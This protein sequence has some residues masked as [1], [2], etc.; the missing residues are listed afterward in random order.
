WYSSDFASL[1]AKFSSYVQAQDDALQHRT[2]FW[3][4]VG[5]YTFGGHLVDPTAASLYS[6]SSPT[7]SAVS[8]VQSQEYVRASLQELGHVNDSAPF[9][10]DSLPLGQAAMLQHNI[11]WDEGILATGNT[12]I[13]V[14]L[15]DS[16]D[17]LWVGVVADLIVAAFA[18]I[19]RLAVYMPHIY[20]MVS[21][22]QRLKHRALAAV[23]SLSLTFIRRQR[24]RIMRSMKKRAEMHGSNEHDSA[25]AGQLQLLALLYAADEADVD[26]PTALESARPGLRAR[27]HSVQSVDTS[28]MSEFPALSMSPSAAAASSPATRS[29]KDS[30]SFTTYSMLVSMAPSIT[31]VLLYVLTVYLHQAVF[32]ASSQYTAD[33]L[34]ANHVASAQAQYSAAVM[35]FLHVGDARAA[36][37]SPLAQRTAEQGGL[38]ISAFVLSR[39]EA[40]ARVES[41]ERVLR[42]GMDRI[43]YAGGLVY[44]NISVQAPADLAVAGQ[45]QG[46]VLESPLQEF[47]LGTVC[48]LPDLLGGKSTLTGIGFDAAL[49]TPDLFPATGQAHEKNC[50]VAL[51]G[52]LHRT[53]LV[54]AVQ[55]FIL[56]GRQVVSSIPLSDDTS[57]WQTL[58]ATSADALHRVRAFHSLD[59]SHMRHAMN[60]LVRLYDG[61]FQV[62]ED[63]YLWSFLDMMVLIP[64]LL[65]SV[66]ALVW[67]YML[68]TGADS[69]ASL[70]LL[71]LIPPK[72]LSVTPSAA[73]DG[74]A[75]YASYPPAVH[76]TIT[77][78]QTVASHAA[79]SRTEDVSLSFEDDVQRG[80]CA[81]AAH[82][83]GSTGHLTALSSGAGAADGYDST[84]S[85]SDADLDS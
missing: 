19:L 35:D 28:D 2:R 4:P 17:L 45:V 61:Q 39:A 50:S 40:A 68:Q 79:S 8:P 47:L 31:L 57:T 16:V 15:Q 77:R 32:H 56:F 46:L 14:L 24:S 75:S 36:A 52:L 72:E 43:M 21:A 22:L 38:N 53:G 5:G 64:L 30:S 78:I 82:D 62:V 13:R 26:A 27:G 11:E 41:A 59:E 37:A 54:G 71:L 1:S 83:S 80:C 65:I 63:A 42:A 85:W 3:I 34:A 48:E 81:K 70:S 6:V 29:T 7:P 60:D 25:T 73:I 69:L 55:V 23:S 18:V 67:P 66:F 9:D 10:V 58:R 20:R 74:A 51:S 76:E 44:P 49:T 84:E 12:T 33:M